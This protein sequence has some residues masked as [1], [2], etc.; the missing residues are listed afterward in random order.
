MSETDEQR[1]I[2]LSAINQRRLARI[3][4]IGRETDRYLRT[5]YLT[6]LRATGYPDNPIH[7]EISFLL[8]TVAE[9]L[10]TES[11]PPQANELPWYEECWRLQR[12]CRSSQCPLLTRPKV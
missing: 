8:L 7:K 11:N 9:F 4:R 5:S 2:R 6:K 3:V 1:T 12:S 10:A